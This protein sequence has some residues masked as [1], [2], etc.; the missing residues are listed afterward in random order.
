MSKIK[1]IQF[2]ADSS[3][4]GAPVHVLNILK[5]FDKNKFDV[6]LLCPRGWL[7]DE[8]KKINIEYFELNATRPYHYGRLGKIKNLLMKF[9]PDLV[10]IHGFRAGFI[11]FYMLADLKIKKIYTEH[12]YTSDFHLRDKF[13]ER[14]QHNFLKK[15]LR[16]ADLVLCPSKAVKDFLE[17]ISKSGTE[18]KVVA[19]GIESPEI[20]R[21]LPQ[22]GLFGFIGSLNAN[23]GI[24][25]LIEGMPKVVQFF[26]EAR[27]EIIGSGELLNEVKQKSHDNKSIKIIENED[28]IYKKLINW[29]FIVVPSYSESFGQVVLDA[30][31]L[32]RPAIANRGGALPEVVRDQQT[33]LI[34]SSNEPEEISNAVMKLLNNP[35]LS[36]KLGK[37]AYEDFTKKYTASIMYQKLEEIYL[38]VGKIDQ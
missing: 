33:G 35:S 23:K 36:V 6:A 11:A 38:K 19:N 32:G 10:H 12:L 24:L 18:I 31:S 30:A 3:K 4:T 16:F 37:L 27:L 15:I 9:D 14:M 5:N 28:N 7:A 34:I 8:A 22:P 1:I 2:I 21:S 20:T 17:S 29:N 13:R 25:N 26:P